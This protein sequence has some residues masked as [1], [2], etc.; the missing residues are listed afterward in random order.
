MGSAKHLELERSQASGILQYLILQLDRQCPHACIYCFI[1]DASLER[2]HNHNL[3][4]SERKRIIDEAYELG[5]RV[6]SMPGDGEPLA[7]RAF[8]DLLTH[9]STKGMISIIYTKG[10]LLTPE[11]TDFLAELNATVVI[12]LD[13]LNERTAT[14]LNPEPCGWFQKAM[15][16]VEYA[17]NVFR[18]LIERKGDYNVTRLVV[19]HMVN[20]LNFGQQEDIKKWC[21]DDMLFVCHGPSKEGC[22]RDIWG[23]L[24]GSDE[25]HQELITHANS[26]SETRGNTTAR[27]DGKCAYYLNGVTVGADG[28][29]KL[30]PAST[31][32]RDLI[33]NVKNDSIKELYDRTQRIL[34]STMGS[35]LPP[36]L[37]RSPS[38]SSVILGLESI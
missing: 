20:L 36:C 12:S 37:V 27:A 35:A 22:A 10:L 18:S 32:T 9:I 13:S 2:P 28:N 14:E 29:V 30:C 8:K 25:T 1:G 16:N 11:W 31:Q 7:I 24:A 26:V 4:L 6:V 3:S 34:K 15:D 5:A 38:Y 17:R 33:G 21:G 19:N 23:R